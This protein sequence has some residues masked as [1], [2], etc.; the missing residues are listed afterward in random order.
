MWRSTG[1]IAGVVSVIVAVVVGPAWAGTT[2]VTDKHGD[3]PKGSDLVA[4]TF[5]Y[6]GDTAHAKASVKDLRGSGVVA[7]SIAY[8]DNHG[9]DARGVVTVQAVKKPGHRV[10]ARVGYFREFGSRMHCP[11]TVVTWDAK[12]DVATMEVTMSCLEEF[13]YQ[14]DEFHVW[15]KSWA[16]DHSGRDRTRE[17]TVPMG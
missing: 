5:S 11:D 16:L 14:A 8:E 4:A 15:A 6:P 12:H 13:L 17:F 2:R 9:P 10:T 1:A 7:W 3:A